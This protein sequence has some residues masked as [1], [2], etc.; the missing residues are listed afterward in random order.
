ML[1]IFFDVIMFIQMSIGVFLY[2][3]TIDL[4]FIE[5]YAAMNTPITN[6]YATS[7]RYKFLIHT[8]DLSLETTYLIL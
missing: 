7:Y 6:N 3:V 2:S 8:F 4:P 5:G 1:G